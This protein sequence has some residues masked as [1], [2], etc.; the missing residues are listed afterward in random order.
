MKWAIA[1]YLCLFTCAGQS[2][3]TV[4]QSSEFLG[5]LD[6]RVWNFI[7]PLGD[8]TVSPASGGILLNL[9]GGPGHPLF[10]DGTSRAVAILQP[11]PDQDF[12]IEVRF[13]NVPGNSNELQGF[14][15]AQDSTNLLF[16]ELAGDSVAPRIRVDSIAAGITSTLLDV[17]L[18]TSGSDFW[19]RL[20]RS[21]SYWTT[22]WSYNGFIFTSG[23]AFSRNMTINRVGLFAANT[24]SEFGPTPAFSAGFAYFHVLTDYTPTPLTLSNLSVAPSLTTAVVRWS[25]SSASDSRV[26]W[27]SSPIYDN[28]ITDPTPRTDHTLTLVGLAC[29]STYHL[30]ARST[31]TAAGSAS[32]ADT[33]FSTTAC[34][35]GAIA[36]DDF[37]GTALNTARWTWSSPD[38][39]AA[40]SMSGTDVLLSL[41]S[42][43]DGTNG[44]LLQAVPDIDFQVDAKFDSVPSIA[45]QSQGII[46]SQDDANDV[47]FAVAYDLNGPTLVGSVS[48][49]GTTVALPPVGLTRNAAPIWLR[50]QRLG[51][52]WTF[53]WSDDGSTF[54][55][56]A[57][58]RSTLVVKYLGL[59][60]TNGSRLRTAP[61]F[62]A[63]VDYFVERSAPLVSYD[64]GQ[65]DFQRTVIDPNPPAT[66]LGKALAD[67]DG[68]GHPDAIVGFSAPSPGGIFWYRAPASGRPE[69][70]WTKYTVLPEG[71]AFDDLAAGDVNGDAAIDVV[72]SMNGPVY[73]F[74]NP[75]GSGGDPAAGRWKAHLVAPGINGKSIV[76]ADVDRDG[77]L[78]IV[79]DS[80][81]AFQ[82]GPDSWEV[83]D[84]GA[85]FPGIYAITGNGVALLDIG[86]GRG[87][88][89]IVGISRA[90]QAISWFENP[91]E[92]GGNPRRDPWIAHTIGPAFGASPD[93]LGA[94]ATADLN[95][96]GHIDVIT[97]GKSLGSSIGFLPGLTWW[98]AP[99]DPRNGT[100]T[101]HG[102]DSSFSLVQKLTAADFDG[103]GNPD[104][105]AAQMDQSPGRRLSVFYSDGHGNLN[106]QVLSN[107][108][109][110]GFAVTDPGAKGRSSILNSA[111]GYFGNAHPLE[112][113]LN[114]GRWRT[115]N[116]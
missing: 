91:L 64:R 7:N 94:F 98:E 40:V 23:A 92:H 74:E 66:V 95:G 21:G 107:G 105:V 22:S 89:N 75:R 70:T 55:L 16:V 61:A 31:S 96:D 71:Y 18:T 87:A 63:A 60:A 108:A 111:H 112:L 99:A 49:A 12:S 3:V 65:V 86:S 77:K 43:N 30:R 34:G 8:A 102:I 101:R 14:M 36:S 32:S 76:L 79:T 54:Q 6:S 67:I 50:I 20:T 90:P 110:C 69:D 9:P 72:A 52:A 84:Y 26:D 103:D 11:A 113:W 73:W 97:A 45:Y 116:L 37:T 46:A 100:W 2:P 39:G 57:Q 106:Q 85:I 29:G 93:T 13:T 114:V 41:P 80:Y 19:L 10:V 81:I 83:V 25:T 24:A 78:D 28:S 104:I 68:D 51:S 27:G 82:N 109:G 48:E 62:T 42:G 58:V 17:P 33:S 53:Y 1:G 35:G 88:I 59:I 56:A 5:G 38:I 47:R 15:A 115:P 4:L 44:R